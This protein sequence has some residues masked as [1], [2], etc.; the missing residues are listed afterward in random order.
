MRM[1]NKIDCVT[2]TQDEAARYLGI[3]AFALQRSRNPNYCKTSSLK[4]LPFV[5][6][7]KSVR[8]LKSDIDKFLETIK[9]RPYGV[10]Q[11]DETRKV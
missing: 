3:S 1:E 4:S 7:G 5:Q 8:Y 2:F 6:L 9:N 10:A 11:V